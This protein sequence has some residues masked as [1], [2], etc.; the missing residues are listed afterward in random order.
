M[1]PSTNAWM[2]LMISISKLLWKMDSL[3]GHENTKLKFVSII[4]LEIGSQADV[5]VLSLATV[6]TTGTSDF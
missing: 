6:A 1:E 4:A 2:V 3:G 5:G